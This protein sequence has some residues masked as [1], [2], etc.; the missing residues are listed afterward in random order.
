MELLAP[1][2]VERILDLGCGDG[3]LTLEFAKLGCMVVGVDS[4]SEMVAA[5]KWLGLTAQVMNGHTLP[6][7]N[8]FD[9][10]FSHAAKEGKGVGSIYRRGAG[11]WFIWFL[12]SVSFVWF[13]ERE[14]LER[15]AHQINGRESLFAACPDNSTFN[16][17]H[18]APPSPPLTQR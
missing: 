18:S 8:K 15:P 5:A 9:A 17:E 13:D 11:D 3:A 4:R 2:P 7:I 10:V 6:F 16:I 14:R 1:K 12:W